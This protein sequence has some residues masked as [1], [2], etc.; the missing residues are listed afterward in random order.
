M[1]RFHV[2]AM[3]LTNYSLTIIVRRLISGK[4]HSRKRITRRTTSSLETLAVIPGIWRDVCMAYFYS[5][6][7]LDRWPVVTELQCLFIPNRRGHV[8]YGHRDE[9]RIQ[10]IT[11]TTGSRSPTCP[12]FSDRSRDLHSRLT[13]RK[14][15][16]GNTAFGEAAPLWVDWRPAL[17]GADCIERTAAGTSFSRRDAPV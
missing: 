2:T 4:S 9:Y 7:T 13:N 11:S 16:I 6:R 3:W 12:T 8:R 14:R 1:T 5:N 10:R 17:N 15:P